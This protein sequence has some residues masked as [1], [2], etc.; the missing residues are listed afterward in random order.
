MDAVPYLAGAG[1]SL[2]GRAL[3]DWLRPKHAT[4]GT[5]GE[6][7]VDFW[8]IEFRSAVRE[9]LQSGRQAMNLLLVEQN[10]AMEDVLINQ[11][12]IMERLTTLLERIK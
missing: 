6:R 10:R 2:V 1:A 8:R 4:N 3:F 7:S 12:M 5:S 9:E 11:R